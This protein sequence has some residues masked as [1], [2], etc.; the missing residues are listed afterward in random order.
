MGREKKRRMG[1]KRGGGNEGGQ[2]WE[3]GLGHSQRK[4][5]P[6]YVVDYYYIVLLFLLY[7]TLRVYVCNVSNVKKAFQKYQL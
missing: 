5:L 6:Y 4:Q 7:T 3:M 1:R 2:K